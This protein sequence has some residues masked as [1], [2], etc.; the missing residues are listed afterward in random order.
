MYLKI[1]SLTLLAIIS[2]SLGL[3]YNT[4]NTCNN[5]Y[6]LVASEFELSGNSCKNDMYIIHSMDTLVQEK[7]ILDVRTEQY[8]TRRS[9]VEQ[10]IANNKSYVPYFEEQLFEAP[11]NSSFL[12][13]NITT[14]QHEIILQSKF[15]QQKRKDIQMLSTFNS[16]FETLPID[17][18]MS[19]HITYPVTSSIPKVLDTNIAPARLAQERKQIDTAKNYYN[20]LQAWRIQHML[21]KVELPILM[22]HRIKPYDSFPSGSKGKNLREL[23]VEPDFFLK[24]LDILQ[25]QDYI[26]TNFAEIQQAIIEQNAD[27]FLRKNIVLTFDD[28]YKEHFDFV[29]PELQKRSM[30]GVFGIVPSTSQISV[31]N[32]KTMA[33]NNME[34]IPHTQSHCALA[35]INVNDGRKNDIEGIYQKCANIRYGYAQQPLQP[36]QEVKFEIL[37]SSKKIAEIT[38]KTPITFMYPYGSYN[39]QTLNIL[40]EN[41]FIFGMTAWGGSKQ[42]FAKPY[43][44]NRTIVEG[45]KDT[46]YSNW[47]KPFQPNELEN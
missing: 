11:T 16:A 5:V 23:T 27:F 31:P 10:L 6:N 37:E 17:K 14:K 3:A 15:D 21:G 2:F 39:Q 45:H 12:F 42:D 28:S 4:Y 7:A 24:Q 13:K 46:E 19:F 8:H 9:N 33:T 38:G 32:L 36:L 18:Q 41:Q 34:L 29:F 26:T 43:Q 30:K 35:S 20:V 25:Q 44:L 40:A 22:Y 1:I 47:F